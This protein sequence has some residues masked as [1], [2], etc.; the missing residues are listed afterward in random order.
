MFNYR[1]LPEAADY[2]VVYLCVRWAFLYVLS[3]DLLAD[4]T[5]N[6]RDYATVLRP[7]VRPSVCLSSVLWLVR[8]NFNYRKSV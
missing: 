5:T 3:L 8:I 1:F 6:G 4:R 2:S 7:S